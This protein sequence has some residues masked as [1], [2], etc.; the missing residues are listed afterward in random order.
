MNNQSAEVAP[1]G[2]GSDGD[3]LLDGKREFPFALLDRATKT[4]LLT[5][6]VYAQNLSLKPGVRLGWT[7]PFELYVRDMFD[8]RNGE[9]IGLPASALAGSK[10]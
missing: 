3:I 1:Y 8:Y 2:D 9:I 7:Y 5:R 4:Y 6:T 10:E